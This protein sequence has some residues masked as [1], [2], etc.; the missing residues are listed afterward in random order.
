MYYVALLRDFVGLFRAKTFNDMESGVHAES[1]TCR[2]IHIG[3]V[4][5]RYV[6]VRSREWVSLF[7]ATPP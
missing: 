6:G 3:S 1:A 7:P 2:I 5:V 4:G